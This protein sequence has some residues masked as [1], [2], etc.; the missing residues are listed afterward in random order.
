MKKLCAILLAA[1]II[2]LGAGLVIKYQKGKEISQSLAEPFTQIL[3]EDRDLI[4]RVLAICEM[5]D[6][7]DAFAQK[8]YDILNER[9]QWWEKNQDSIKQSPELAQMIDEQWMD[10]IYRLL[11][12]LRNESDELKQG[13]KG[14]AIQLIAIRLINKE[15]QNALQS[16]IEKRMA[17]DGI[18]IGQFR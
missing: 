5:D 7:I 9:Q 18:E 11:L 15:N 2:L 16:Y 10:A 17:A 8:V 1:A 4:D 14:T 3:K 13:K 6:D 12:S